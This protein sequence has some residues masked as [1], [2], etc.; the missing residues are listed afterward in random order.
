MASNP[1]PISLSPTIDVHIV[2]VL[3]T[4]YSY[5]IHDKSTATATAV[6]PAEPQKITALAAS[7]NVPLKAS[8]TT[9]HHWDHAGGNLE[10]A[11]LVP[12]IAILGSAYET[13]DG[14]THRLEA[15]THH[16]PGSSFA[17]TALHTPCHTNGHLCYAMDTPSSA[18]FS[19]DTLF[20]AGCGKFF[21]GSAKEMET[22]LNTTLAGL[23]DETLVFCGHE[24]TVSNLVFARHIDPSNLRVRAKLEWAKKQVENGA[25]TVPSNIAD[26]KASNPFM[27]TQRPEIAKAVGLASGASP[28][29]VMHALRE[30]KN[31]F[32]PAKN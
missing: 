18:L 4:N 8:L 7:L 26:E 25:Y 21:E 9:H 19:G 13:A 32:R 17:V 24:Y 10:L 22:S 14:V 29:Q 23:P 30:S 20:V 1:L 31:N 3:S 27:R 11:S 6:D 15:G 28:V 12:G 5:L 16:V 2:P